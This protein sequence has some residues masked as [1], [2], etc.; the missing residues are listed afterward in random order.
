[1]RLS[2]LTLV[3][4]A[5]LFISCTGTGSGAGQQAQK[6]ISQFDRAGFSDF[7]IDKDGNYHAVFQESPAIGKPTFIYYSVSANKGASWS[8]PVALSNDQTGNGAGCPRILQDAGGKIYVIWKRYGKTGGYPAADEILDGP[9]GY[10]VGTLFYKV[11]SGGAWS[12]Q[13][14]INEREARQASWFAA[15]APSGGVYVFWSQLYPQATLEDWHHSDYLRMAGLNGTG[16]VYKDLNAPPTPP[17]GQYAY[18]NPTDG[19]INLEGYIDRGGNVHLV[20]EDNVND[21]QELKYFDGHAQKVVYTYPKYKEGN[22]FDNPG[23]LLVDE[24]GN[25][26]LIFLPCEATLESEQLWD[27]NLATNQTNVLTSIEKPNV[28]IK[29]FQ[30]NQGPNGA[31]AI[32]IEAGTVGE[33]N[34]AFGIYYDRGTWK[35][36][37]LTR[38]A[39]KSKFFSKDFVGAGGYLANISLSTTYSSTFATVAYGADGRKNM[40]MTISEHTVGNGGYGIDNPFIVYS[41]IDQ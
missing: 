7:L 3:L 9:G 36:V 40:L 8:K 30:A 16:I 23:R 14:Q 34:E 5:V 32:T 19:A 33:T 41:Q 21:T 24:K 4:L 25:D 17:P 28:K 10:R 13:L 29:G 18:F 37:G 31:M 20:Y 22:T 38:N 2:Q 15:V 26:H 39:S 1:M 11:L 35:D 27:I 6:K 12:N